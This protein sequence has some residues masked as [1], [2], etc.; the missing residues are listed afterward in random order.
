MKTK[1]AKKYRVNWQRID[2]IISALILLGMGILSASINGDG[3]A[4][5]FLVPMALILLFDR[6]EP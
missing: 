3:T 6:R 4:F 5:M 1:R 2:T